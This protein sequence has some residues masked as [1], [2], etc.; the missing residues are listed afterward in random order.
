M[1]YCSVLNCKNG[2]YNRPDLGYFTF[3]K[4][5]IERLNIWL[6]FCRRNDRYFRRNSRQAKSGQGNNLR[7][8]SVHFRPE[9][10]KKS[11]TG[12]YVL[13]GNAN[14]EIFHPTSP[15]KAKDLTN[16]T[17]KRP[18]P[19]DK[20]EDEVVIVNKTPRLSDE[21]QNTSYSSSSC[22]TN[23]VFDP[24]IDHS[25]CKREDNVVSPMGKTTRACQTDLSMD[26]L[27]QWE[28]Q[29][30]KLKS[31][32]AKLLNK[33][34]NKAALKRD[35]F[36]EDVIKSD[37]SVKFY[38]G[39]PSHACLLML[40]DTHH[41]EAQKLKY[42]DKNKDKTMSYELNGRKKP[43]PKRTLSLMQEFILTL[44]RLRLGLTGKQLGDIFCISESQVSCIVT[45]WVCF[46]ASSFRETLVLW[47]SRELVSRKL[48][49]TFKKYPK[50]RVILDCTEMF[51][52]KP[53]S[54]HAQKATWSEYKQHN[55]IK[56]LVGITPNGYFSFLSKFWSGSTSDRKITQESGIIDML[57]EGDSVMA[58][59]GFNI[60]D[61]LTRRKV[62]L[63]IPPSS[64]KGNIFFIK[65]SI[66]AHPISNTLVPSPLQ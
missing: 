17:P 43:G 39:I 56:C 41:A 26:D 45:T 52:E 12:R 19:G 47:P 51:I 62:Y 22:S 53:T 60:R 37:E 11:L 65:I 34:S 6:D 63:N 1:V 40:F 29:V 33:C 24:F 36:H 13:V 35:L 20:V 31:E 32:N 9:Q 23:T 14:P 15:E 27:R 16:Q 48:P 38:T 44:V 50:T 59:R 3:P 58:D 42:W 64:K 66:R 61:L 55:T 4:G 5:Q 25:Y 18:F 8:C 54:P 30:N 49:R 7:L 2:H 57:E 46:L 21:T 28:E 10:Y